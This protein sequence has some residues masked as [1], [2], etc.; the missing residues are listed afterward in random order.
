MCASQDRLF[1]TEGGLN[2]RGE[3]RSF[4]IE[5]LVPSLVTRRIVRGRTT[6]FFFGVLSTGSFP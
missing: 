4:K 6:P 5:H 1:F 2:V 3:F